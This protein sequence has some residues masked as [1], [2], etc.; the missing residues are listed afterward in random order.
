MRFI[1]FLLLAVAIAAEIEKTSNGGI[2]FSI[3][4]NISRFSIGSLILP[5]VF[6]ILIILILFARWKMDKISAKWD[7]K[8][9]QKQELEA[10]ATE[11]V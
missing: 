3:T 8:R 1:V 7:Q 5:A 6:F 2:S 9:K 10:L 11:D 4:K